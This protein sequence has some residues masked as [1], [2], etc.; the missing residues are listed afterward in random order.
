[1]SE[2]KIYLPYILYAVPFFVAAII[3]IKAKIEES[4]PENVV[5]ERQ[6]EPAEKT[7]LREVRSRP[8]YRQYVSFSS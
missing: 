1:M 2:I 8:I 7:M 4:R 3:L 6:I 5:H